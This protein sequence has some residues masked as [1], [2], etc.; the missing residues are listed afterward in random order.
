MSDFLKVKSA[1]EV[2]D[3]VRGFAPLAAEEVALEAACGRVLARAAAAGEAIPAFPRATMDGYAVRA[4]DTFGASES[5]PALLDVSGRVAMGEAARG[6]LA[7][8]KAVDIPTGGMLPAGADA[9][10]MVEHT[11][12]VDGAGIEVNRPVAPGENVLQVG[13]DVALGQELFPAGKRLRPQ[14]VGLLAA[15]GATRVGVHRRPRVAVISTGDEIVPVATAPL[16]L[17]KVRDINT[18]AVAAQVEEAGAVAARRGIVAD[19]L[20]ALLAACREA[21]ASHDVVLL[22][23]GSSVGIRDYTLRVVEGLPNAELLVHGVAIRPGKPT[24]LARV[25]PKALWGLPGQP[26]SAMIVVAAFVR[27]LLA[28]LAG[29]SVEAAA[30]G[31]TRRAVL[32]HR[33]PSVHGR[34]DYLR[35]VLAVEGGRVMATPVFGKSAMISTLALADGYVV[36]PEHVEGYDSGEEV[37]VHLFDS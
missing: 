22:S 16:P 12:A 24:L 37:T 3:I 35:V 23:G 6:S 15:L 20:K 13:E 27:P 1:A 26:V 33:L 34:A 10:V 29:E 11:Q 17:G 19:D 7:P 25:G 5:F 30:S 8:G 9:V 36:V 32:K 21:L 18:L 31:A 2:L 28:V 4:R 14:D